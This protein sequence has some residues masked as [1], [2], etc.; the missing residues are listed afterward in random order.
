MTAVATAPT[1]TTAPASTAQTSYPAVERAAIDASARGPV[2]FFFGNGLL[3][4]MLA[5]VLGLITSIQLAFPTFLADV[6]FLSYG[7]IWPAFTNTISF[8]WG[9]LAGLGVT[10]WLLAR[11]GRVQV[12]FPGV[13]VTGAVFWQVGLT[14]G[15]LSILGGKTTGL[16][17]LEIPTGSAVLMLLGYLLIAV[18]ALL[19]FSFRSQST[20]FI[21]V[22]YL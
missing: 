12:K 9:S 5:T 18:W 6:P 10:I 3:W 7:R 16:E 13:L 17:G 4:L 8:G 19:L 2:L 14:Y 15:I 11:L 1:S 22:W 20:P 21:S